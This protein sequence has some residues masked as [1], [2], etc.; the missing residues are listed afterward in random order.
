[1]WLFLVKHYFLYIRFLADFWCY[2]AAVVFSIRYFQNLVPSISLWWVFSWTLLC[3]T[4]WV[5][6]IHAASTPSRSIAAAP[7]SMYPTT[8]YTQVKFACN[9][10]LSYTKQN[11][12]KI[13]L[14][15]P[16]R[17]TLYTYEC[18]NVF[19]DYQHSISLLSAHMHRSANRFCL[20]AISKKESK[21]Q[22]N[23][24]SLALWKHTHSYVCLRCIHLEWQNNSI[25][26]S[27]GAS[28]SISPA[29]M[30]FNKE[31]II[32]KSGD[33]IGY[34]ILT[35]PRFCTGPPNSAPCTVH[36]QT[37]TVWFTCSCCYRSK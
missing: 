6:W 36:I 13:L 7:Q 32:L 19:C 9:K 30:K 34:F 27:R 29:T 12:N 2:V 35:L 37:Y 18:V 10:M 5:R 14:L 21:K 26:F 20:F 4:H 28:A 25:I 11:T 3:R 22:F 31:V 8:Y 23:E 16:A 1:M 33:M 24:I 15:S 17:N